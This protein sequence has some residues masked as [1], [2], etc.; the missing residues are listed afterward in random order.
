VSDLSN[1][2]G[3]AGE[4]SVFGF[5]AVTGFFRRPF[6]GD[7]IRRQFAEVGSKSLPLVIAA[8]FAL[9]AVLTLHTRSMLVTFGAT[10]W[11]PSVQALAF[12]LEIG[13]L[14]TGLLVAGRVGSGI[15]AVLADMRATEQIDA[16]ESLSID[17][18]KLL[19]MPRIVACTLALPLL[20]L[21]L[22][23]SGLLGGFLSEYASSRVSFQFYI[24]QSFSAFVWSNFWAPTL[25]TAVFGFTIGTIS[26]FLGYTTNEGA[27]GVGKAATRSVVASS[28]LII[29]LDVL[30]IKFIFFIFPD[31]A[32]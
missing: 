18:F 20:T 22:D 25:K 14:V 26:S 4:V 23:F 17:S 28:L 13:P 2:F 15:G 27:Q 3:I 21:F 6:E 31:S 19:V 10:A 32:L 29:I 30:L 5:R 1:V 11:I 9:G 7:Q 8:G 12:F 16:I 24:S